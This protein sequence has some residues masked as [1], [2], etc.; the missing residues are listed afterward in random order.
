MLGNRF[1]KQTAFYTGFAFLNRGISFLLIPV[2]TRYL[3]PEDYGIYSLFLTAVIVSDPFLTFSVHDAIVLVYYDRSFPIRE[4]VSTFC[5]FCGGLFVLQ[6]A[7]IGGAHFAPL[8]RFAPPLFLMLAPL[9]AVS[10]IM[11]YIMGLLWQVR[12]KPTH[13]GIFNLGCILTQLVLNIW[14]VVFLRLGWRGLLY[15]Q[16]S[17]AC[18]I[19]LLTLFILRRSGWLGLC[20]NKKCLSFGLKFGVGFLPNVLAEKLND[21]VGR[22]LIAENFNLG[23]TGIFAMGQKLGTV[24]GLYS[25]SFVNA[26]R[27]WL[28][29][30][31]ADDA[32]LD[33]RKIILSVVG[34]CASFAVFALGGSLLM[35][36]LS[37]FVLGNEFQSSVVY[38]FWFASAY[39]L[40]GMYS[41]VSLFIYRTAKTWI[42]SALTV[43]ATALNVLFTWR[44]LQIF[45]LMGAAYAPVLAWAVTLALSVWTAVRLWKNRASWDKCGKACKNDPGGNRH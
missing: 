33:E 7:C 13:Y 21:S 4:Y 32:C 40:S 38:V 43:I 37:G 9:G 35:Y 30:K 3:T 25:S 6:L 44:F 16:G 42:L 29:K 15:T 34:G 10:N 39:T 41:V 19:T 12:E 8:G 22:L 18:L 31:L 23:A 14:S 24:V 36:L 26:Y 27:P 1:L 28:F 2:F 5:L 17:M 11:V 45:G 20:F